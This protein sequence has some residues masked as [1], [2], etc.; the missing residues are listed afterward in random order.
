F[1]TKII[2]ISLIIFLFILIKYSLFSLFYQAW[3]NKEKGVCF[4]KLLGFLL[5]P[6]KISFT[7]SKILKVFLAEIR[8]LLG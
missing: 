7:Q 6:N 3:K 8:L 1:F 4:R 2:D 5:A